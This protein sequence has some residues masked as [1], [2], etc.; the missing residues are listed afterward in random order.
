MC[1]IVDANVASLLF[2][3]DH[4]GAAAVFFEW[5][6]TGTGRLVV[7]GRLRTELSEVD[8]F[9]EWQ[10]EAAIA[11]RIRTVNDEEVETR[12]RV[13]QNKRLCR[14]DDDHIIALAQIS[15]ARL[16]YSHDKKLHKDF[17]DP[18]LIAKPR[19]KIYST[20]AG[21]QLLPSHKQLLDRST[22]PR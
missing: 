17:R 12:T 14:S 7:G 1:A 18:A 11:G 5:I 19:G 3:S 8:S 9:L 21:P 15:G 4:T 10:R 6:N 16:L 22:C 13:I 2:R 20:L